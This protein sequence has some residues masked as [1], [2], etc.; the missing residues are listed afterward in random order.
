MRKSYLV[1][2][3]F[4]KWFVISEAKS[5]SKKRRWLCRCDCGRE[6]IVLGHTLQSG[7]SRGCLSCRAQCRKGN[8]NSNWKGGKWKSKDGYVNVPLG[9]KYEDGYIAEHRLVMQKFLGRELQYKETVHHKNGIRHDN[10]LENLELWSSHHP[11]GQRV[12]DLIQHAKEVL[13]C[14]E[15]EALR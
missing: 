4:N 6:Q 10:R 8:L 9:L 2:Q 5:T 15:P 14:Y 7:S 12:S 11:S 3:Q 13:R 1:G